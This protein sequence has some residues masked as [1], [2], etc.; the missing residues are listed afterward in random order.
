MYSRSRPQP[1]FSR[2]LD[3]ALAIFALIITAP[4]MGA[5][6]IAI[7][8]D[9]G[10]PIGFQQTRVGRNGQPLRMHK[11]RTLDLS[12]PEDAVTPEGD[13]R[14]T[15]SGRILRRYRLDELPQLLDVLAGRLAFVGPRPERAVDLANLDASSR[16]QFLAI[17]PGLTGPV[18]LDFIAEDELLANC[19]DPAHTY[20]S[21]LVPAKVAANVRIFAQRSLRADIGCILRTLRVLGSGSERAHSRERV[22]VLLQ[23]REAGRRSAGDEV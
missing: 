7:R 3:V 5:I 11:F 1:R 18:Q 21:V 19:E 16:E 17:Q 2:A 15:R 12:T 22:A 10:R 9:C 13:P 23:T 20:R 14:V 8:L 6:A 4:L